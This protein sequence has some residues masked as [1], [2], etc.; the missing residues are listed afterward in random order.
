MTPATRS[1]Y[2]ACPATHTD[3]ANSNANAI[4][5]GARIQLD[6]SFNVSVQSWPTWEKIIATVLQTYGAYV[7]DTGGAL[8]EI[9]LEVGGARSLLCYKDVV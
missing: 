3:G 1:G 4:P 5:E 7:V 6:P 2:I 9:I 8:A